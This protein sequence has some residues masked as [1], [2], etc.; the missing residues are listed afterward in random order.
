MVA[1]STPSRRHSARA[2]PRIARPLWFVKPLSAQ[3]CAP[4]RPSLDGAALVYRKM[5]PLSCPVSH[6]VRDTSRF[7]F[8]RHLA[9]VPT[10]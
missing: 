2:G 3:E 1:N 6:S 8:Q 10:M 4:P 5:L 7:P 9:P